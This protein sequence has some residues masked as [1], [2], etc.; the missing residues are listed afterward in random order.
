[1]DET[2]YTKPIDPPPPP[3][4]GRLKK[5]TMTEHW[6]ID[7]KNEWNASTISKERKEMKRRRCIYRFPGFM[8][9]VCTRPQVVSLGPYHYGHPQF[10]PMEKL[11]RRMLG[12][13]L[14][15]I[16]KDLEEAVA[17]MRSEVED[18]MMAYDG[19]EAVWNND[20]ERFVQLMVVDG[21]FLLELHFLM[22]GMEDDDDLRICYDEIWPVSSAVHTD[23]IVLENQVPIR[24]LE[25]MAELGRDKVLLFNSLLANLDPLH[26]LFDK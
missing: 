15:K 14:A 18:L 11:K 4:A 23:T 22:H 25:I 12:Y 3:P 26:G 21:C 17:A 1:M 20:K 19:L 9:T 10:K 2:A 6:I 5:S 8:W 16:G 7:L 24:A 13:Y